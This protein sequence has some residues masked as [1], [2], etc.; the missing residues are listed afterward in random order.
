MGHLL[1]PAAAHVPR[2]VH[3]V[4][5]PCQNDHGLANPNPDPNPDPNP[6]PD[7]G[8]A[9]P[10]LVTPAQPHTPHQNNYGLAFAGV[11]LVD[12]APATALATLP[13]VLTHAYAGSLLS[14][15]L[16]LAEGGGA[17]MPSS[18][19]STALGGLSALGTG[20]LLRELARGLAAD[21][22]KS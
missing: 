7:A 10:Y 13:A 18:P 19:A 9:E 21:D 4:R 8:D 20:L 5:M 15:L 16:A 17:A 1:S 22:V 14:S 3:T 12:Y 6:T 11:R 2:R